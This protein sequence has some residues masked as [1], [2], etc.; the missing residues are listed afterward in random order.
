MISSDPYAFKRKGLA[1][2]EV[3][4]GNHS[5]AMFYA[6]CTI[7][8]ISAGSVH[9]AE[10]PNILILYA[11]DMGYGDFSANVGK[12]S[13]VQTPVLDHLASEGMRFTDGHSSS[14]NCSPS[15]YAM[16]TGR[17]HWRKF[18]GIVNAFEDSRFSP[19]RLTLPEMLKE[20]GYATGAIGKWHLGWNWEAIAINS[21]LRINTPY[22]KAK[23]PEAYDWT[24][25]VP[26]G[27]TAH[28][29]DYYFGDDVIN[30]APYTWIE[31]DRILEMPSEMYDDTKWEAPPGGGKFGSRAGPMAPGYNP[32]DNIPKT[33][34]KAIEFINKQAKSDNPFFLY[35]AF[36]S[37]HAPVIPHAA[38]QGKN[39]AGP[40]GDYV[41]ETDYV[42]G[43]ILQ[44]LEKSGQADNTIVVFSTDNGTESLGYKVDV[45]YDHWV[46]GPLRGLK[47]DIYEGGHRLPFVVRWPGVVK[48]GSVSDA[49]VNQVDLMSTFAAVT[50]YE[51]PDDQAEDSFNM[52][53]VW[54]GETGKLRDISI[55]NTRD[56][57]W[58]IRQGDWILVN[59]DHVTTQIRERAK[60]DWYKKHGYPTPEKSVDELYNLKSDIGQ[61]NNVSAQHPEKVQELKALLKKIREQGY[62]S[63]RIG[64]QPR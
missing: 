2:A 46:S 20:K 51:L 29:F 60:P 11:D 17:H 14:A 34:D 42:C 7:A 35:F 19:E 52:L 40:H 5:F 12:D 58:A 41:Y 45:A 27:P 32:W 39:Q 25:P 15:R 16:L 10:M 26:N 56:D 6:L 55:H 61:R 18:F 8:L 3:R 36:P 13:K 50:G 53:P 59:V 44:A 31:N 63:P 1:S 28:G 48:P 4:K 49:L 22:G 33:R 43:E 54:K 30:Y 38:F 62:S 37:P 21:K 47:R 23:N 24:K 9:A 64:K 57:Q